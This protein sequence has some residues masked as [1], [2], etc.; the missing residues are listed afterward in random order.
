[1]NIVAFA[2]SSS[3]LSINRELVKYTLTFFSDANVHL[4][5]LNDYMMPIYS[6]DEEK[7]GFP[8]QV[9][10]FLKAI[11]QS[12]AI[13]CSFAEHN[14]NFSVAFKNI[15]DWASRVN[16]KVFQSKPMLL[17]ATSPGEQGGKNVLEIAQ[18]S[19][20]R[21]GADIQEVFSLPKFNENFSLEKGI[22]NAEL[23]EKYGQTVNSFK[24]KINK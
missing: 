3:S 1:M 4:L 9:H 19:F 8:E 10:S 5:D 18:K 17:M 12:D 23:K 21:F 11:E 15:F 6:A 16:R 24:E 7:K 22:I 20:P 2:G 14:G 13:I